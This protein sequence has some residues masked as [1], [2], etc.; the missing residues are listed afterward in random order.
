[1]VQVFVPAG[2]FNLG[3]GEAERAVL[4][5]LC[6]GCNPDYLNAASPQRRIHLDAY[7]IDQ[8]EVT[9][10]QFAR[11]VAATG[12]RTSAEQKQ[13]SYIFDASLNDFRYVPEANWRAPHGAGSTIAGR[14][15]VAVTQIS[16]VD[17]AA[18]CEWAGRRLPTEAEWEKAARGA[19]GRVYPWG[20]EPPDQTR[21]NFDLQN[22]GPVAV[23]SYPAGASPYGALEMAGNVWEWTSDFYSKT[24]YQTASASN[25][26]GPASGDGHTFR[27]GSW[28]STGALKVFLVS[29]V[30][31]L[32][33]KPGLRSDVLGFRCAATP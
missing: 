14:D 5:A 18:Y 16:W 26:T 13:N 2:E 22:P 11:F 20:N 32:W 33:N 6:P 4:L 7:W 9:N 1:M 21:L 23:G 8:T 19:D 28:A 31:R 24:Y 12:Y 10:A 3:L 25:P 17:A 27:G 29:A 30:G 15:L